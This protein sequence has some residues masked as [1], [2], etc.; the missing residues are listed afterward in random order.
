[1]QTAKE[2]ITRPLEA[3][4]IELIDKGLQYL[5]DNWEVQRQLED[6]HGLQDS[7][8]D[9]R[10]QHMNRWRL[11]SYVPHLRLQVLCPRPDKQ[12]FIWMHTTIS[13]SLPYV[14]YI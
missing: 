3:H 11:L 5:E 6:L 9:P 14:S 12:M 8:H 4:E 2:Y 13:C 10:M 7:S 1:M